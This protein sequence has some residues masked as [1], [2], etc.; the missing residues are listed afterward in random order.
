M[1]ELGS[2]A[3][4]ISVDPL[5]PTLAKLDH[6]R[7]FLHAWNGRIYVVTST[8]IAAVERIEN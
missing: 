3:M 6:L 4:A 7:R 1:Q 8:S 2:G 5:P